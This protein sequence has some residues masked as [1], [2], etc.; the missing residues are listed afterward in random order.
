LL[1]REID[2]L[3]DFRLLFLKLFII[4][5]GVLLFSFMITLFVCENAVEDIKKREVI[6][7]IFRIFILGFRSG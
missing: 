5:T 4:S 2:V 3:P 7:K 6:I 1:R